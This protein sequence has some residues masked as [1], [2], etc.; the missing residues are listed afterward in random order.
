MFALVQRKAKAKEKRGMAS[1]P[2]V[3]VILHLNL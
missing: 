2:K 3:K 1:L